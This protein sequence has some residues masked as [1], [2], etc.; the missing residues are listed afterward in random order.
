MLGMQA[1]PALLPKE[2]K[3]K[4]KKR[5]KC[6]PH[7]GFSLLSELAEHDADALEH[8]GTMLLEGAGVYS[9]LC[10]GVCPAI[11]T[12]DSWGSWNLRGFYADGF[13]HVLEPLET[14]LLKLNQDN[15]D[16]ATPEVD[17]AAKPFPAHRNEESLGR[18]NC[19]ASLLWEI[20][21]EGAQFVVNSSGELL[22][23]F[24]NKTLDES[25]SGTNSYV[26]S[27]TTDA[28]RMTSAWISELVRLPDAKLVPYASPEERTLFGFMPLSKSVILSGR[29]RVYARI[30]MATRMPNN[31]ASIWYA[32]L[33]CSLKGP[34]AARQEEA[35]QVAG[36]EERRYG[37]FEPRLGSLI[38]VTIWHYLF[39]PYGTTCGQTRPIRSAT[40]AQFLCPTNGQK[41]A[42]LRIDNPKTFAETNAG[43]R[44]KLAPKAKAVSS[45]SETQR[46]L[47]EEADALLDL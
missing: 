29:P 30:P 23:N 1:E 13:F 11:E 28:N 10:V 46:R 33:P 32:M 26:L 36:R 24:T 14:K 9:T 44:L 40:L 6:P 22:V 2:K 41:R 35:K 17:V 34:A 21:K 19:R 15:S 4:K 42:L 38:S 8:I 3:K 37:I 25:N 16:L 39:S 27:H 43:E 12:S 20:D 7:G 45:L 31:I 47:M 18:T 5:P